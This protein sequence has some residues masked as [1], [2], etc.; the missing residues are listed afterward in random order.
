MP[1]FG[2]EVLPGP[3]SSG[4][5]TPE[6]EEPGGIEEEGFE[7]GGRGPESILLA[8]EDGPGESGRILR[9]RGGEWLGWGRVELRVDVVPC[10]GSGNEGGGGPNRAGEWF[11]L[12]FKYAAEE[13]EP[14]WE[15]DGLAVGARVAPLLLL[16]PPVGRGG[17]SSPSEL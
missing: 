10:S 12:G 13:E 6:T 15:A 11:G 3:E 1:P 17:D 4:E 14:D 5:Y 2:V 9:L 8:R 7:E 16:L